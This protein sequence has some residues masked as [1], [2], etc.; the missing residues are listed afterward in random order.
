MKPLHLFSIIYYI[1][2]N[3]VLYI[4]NLTATFCYFFTFPP[5]SSVKF[6]HVEHDATR[7]LALTH[8]TERHSSYAPQFLF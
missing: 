7:T 1:K 2:T 8:L 5:I 6:I 3:V 4:L